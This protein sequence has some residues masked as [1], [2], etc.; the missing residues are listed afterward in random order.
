M[1]ATYAIYI[2]DVIK[3]FGDKTKNEYWQTYRRF[4]DFYD[5]H[6]IIKKKVSRKKKL[7]QIYT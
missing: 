5:L 3:D 4:N 2:I 1:K 6:L 7:M